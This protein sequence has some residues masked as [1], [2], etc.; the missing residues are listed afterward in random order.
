VSP[1]EIDLA[2]RQVLQTRTAI[3][4]A[5]LR[6]DSLRMIVAGTDV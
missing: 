3:E 1:K 6:L 5:R 4:Q 2:R